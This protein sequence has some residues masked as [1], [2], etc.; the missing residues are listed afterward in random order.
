MLGDPATWRDLRWL[1]VD[2]TAG[3]VT[4]LLPAALIVYPLEGY[5]LAA[6]LWRVF[7]DG[8]HVGW[9]YGF[10]PISG[11]GSALAGRRP[12]QRAPRGRLLPGPGPA[13]AST[14]C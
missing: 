4:A 7:T 10:V 8:T 1:L 13:A 3:F 6:G 12:R 5:A 11:Q 14:S 2:M 9:W